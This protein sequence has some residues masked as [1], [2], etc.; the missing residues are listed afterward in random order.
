MAWRI[1]G[2]GDEIADDLAT[3]LRVMKS[4]GVD[5]LEPRKIGLPG[6]S[7]KNIVDLTDAELRT[8]QAMLADNGLKCS[9]IGSPVGKAP[10]DVDFKDQKRQLVSAIRAAQALGTNYVRVFAFQLGA[11][12]ATQAR[13]ARA[14]DLFVRLADV[15][16][17]TDSDIRLMLENEH[18]LFDATPD[19]CM[20]FITSSSAGNVGMCFD[21]GNFIHAGVRPFGQA[22]PLLESHVG[23]MH[24][25][26]YRPRD[27]SWVPAGVGDGELPDVLRAADPT[28]V[29]FLSVEPHLANAPWGRGRPKDELWGEA[30]RALRALLPTTSSG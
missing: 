26:D 2:F 12:P 7:A 18:D 25:K 27:D 8:V 19:E 3:Q 29:A 30:V 16:T 6:G 21:P 14:L 24:I 4:L 17:K 9:Q 10:L 5:A 13:R 11:E 28:K 1:S 22:W 23:M 20:Q 15:A